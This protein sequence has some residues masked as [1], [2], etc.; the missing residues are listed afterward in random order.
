MDIRHGMK[1]KTIK[2]VLRRK[3]DAWLETIEDEALRKDCKRG[4]IVTGGCIASMLLGEK[5][6]DFDVYFRR[7]E[8]AVA[9]AHYYT[10]RFADERKARGGVHIPISVQEMD[11]VRGE[12]RV[13]LVVQ[14]AG[15]ESAEGGQDYA[16]FEGRPDE[17][18]G[19]YVS[20]VYDDPGEV[21]DLVE[22][23]QQRAEEASAEA[24]GYRPI[25]LSSNAIM[26]AG[27]VQLI[28]RF[29]G[30]PDE[31]HQNYDFTHCTNYWSS[32]DSSLTLRPEA[33]QALLS[34]T[35]I[36]QGSRYPVC[37]LFRVRKFVR[38]GWRINAGQV[39]KIA[40]QVSDLDLNDIKTLE[41]QLTG[42]DVAY[43]EQVLERCRMIGGDKIESAYLVEIIDR[44]FG[45]LAA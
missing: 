24:C 4:A 39:L 13:R 7:Y 5:V 17:A 37:S 23:T 14:S 31:I 8:T 25:F 42:V 26:L 40:M 12:K 29:Y 36:Y 21:A 1:A 43:F 2:S 11:D 41:D 10:R 6:S 33:L 35:L 15:V 22:A 38:R 18:A 20:E 27:K 3:I 9:V 30:E 44:M 32:K 45:E 16:Y 28:L 34:R 19:E